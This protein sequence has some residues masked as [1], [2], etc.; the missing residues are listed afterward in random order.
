MRMIGRISTGLEARSGSKRTPSER[1]M[2]ANEI[3]VVVACLIL[4]MLSLFSLELTLRMADWFDLIEL[5]L[6][7]RRA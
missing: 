1:T 3:I 6:R 2:K 5:K 4:M 7:M